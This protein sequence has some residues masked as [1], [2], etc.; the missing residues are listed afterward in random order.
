LHAY[1]QKVSF[2]YEQIYEKASQLASGFIEIGLKPKD[3]IAIYSY[4]NYEW[5]LVQL[6]AGLADLILVNINPAYQSEDLAYTLNKV[7]CKILIT[8]SKFKHIDYRKIIHELIPHMEEGT[9]DHLHSKRLPELQRVYKFDSESVPGFHNF[10]ELF[11][12]KRALPEA[13]PED[14]ANIQYTSGTTGQPKACVLSHLNIINNAY[15]I[16]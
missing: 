11:V 16:G 13:K 14:P 7:G 2:T 4:N 6:A 8:S 3:R 1:D 12:P 10:Q 9:R 5:Y 15:L